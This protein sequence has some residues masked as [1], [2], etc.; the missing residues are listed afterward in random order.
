MSA[1]GVTKAAILKFH[2][3]L[4]A[5]THPK[6]V[7]SFAVNPGLIPSH[8][9]DPDDNRVI[10]PEDFASEPR[11]RTDLVSRA[12]EIEWDAAGLA[13]GTFVALCADPRAKILSGMFINS[14]RDLGEMIAAV[15]TDPGRVERERLYTLKV[16]EF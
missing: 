11:M 2:E 5:E 7:T 15:E 12:C 14:E 13:S 4:H 1:E 9:H 10:R 3:H 16:D 6:G 8:L